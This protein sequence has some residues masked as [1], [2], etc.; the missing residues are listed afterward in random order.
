M[1][2]ELVQFGDL[3]PGDKIIGADGQPVT[4]TNVYEKHFP[5]KMYEIEME[6]GEVV[7]ASGNHLWYCESEQDFKFK[8]EYMRLAKVFFKNKT[9]P[10]KEEDEPFTTLNEMITLFG[11]EIDTNL[12]IEKVC[13]SLG[14]SRVGPHVIVEDKYMVKE[15]V[16]YYSYNDLID[17]LNEMKGA[18]LDNKGYFFFGEVRTTEEIA[19]LMEKGVEINIPTRKEIE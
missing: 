4:V 7:Q 1:K 5:D 16:Q 2:T 3:K 6:D 15:T 8:D 9:I 11:N 14:Y 12:F 17:F 19:Q 10:K 13:R 18:V